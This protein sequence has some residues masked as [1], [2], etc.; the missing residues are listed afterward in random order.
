[1]HLADVFSLSLHPSSTT[2]AEII[3]NTNTRMPCKSTTCCTVCFCPPQHLSL[4]EHHGDPSLNDEAGRQHC[5]QGS[6]QASK[7]ASIQN[8]PSQGLH[9]ARTNFHVRQHDVFCVICEYRGRQIR[10]LTV[11]RPAAIR[12]RCCVVALFFFLFS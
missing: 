11:Q 10:G 9:V 6:K 12:T 2:A 7:D 5:S 4:H 3:C 1:M 8:K